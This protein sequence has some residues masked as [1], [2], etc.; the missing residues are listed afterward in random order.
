MVRGTN[1]NKLTI[2]KRDGTVAAR[3]DEDGTILANGTVLCAIATV[4]LA[5]LKAGA[6]IVADV[7]G[8]TLTPVGFRLKFTGTFTTATTIRL[9][10]T[11]ATTPVDIAT[12]AIAAATDGNILTDAGGTGLTI[13]AGFGAALTAGKGIQLRDVNANSAAGGTSIDV[14]VLYI[15]FPRSR[16]RGPIEA[17]CVIVVL[18]PPHASLIR[19]P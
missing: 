4:T 6:T 8:R 11:K 14:L 19:V 17:G 3:I 10:D 5:Q 12:V 15:A 2:S 7:A 1:L 13:G 18:L 9:S 16:D